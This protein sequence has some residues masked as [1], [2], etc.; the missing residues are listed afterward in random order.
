MWNI[1]ENNDT[2]PRSQNRNRDYVGIGV[3]GHTNLIFV[4][5]LATNKGLQR[6]NPFHFQGR[7]I[8]AK[9]INE[10]KCNALRTDFFI[11]LRKWI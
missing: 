11:R 1:Q 3:T 6:I 4:R 5:Y 8:K 10:S 9:R 7:K 2:N